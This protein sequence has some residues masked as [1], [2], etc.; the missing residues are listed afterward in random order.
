[1]PTTTRGKKIQNE[2]D[3]NVRQGNKWNK[4]NNELSWDELEFFFCYF[5]SLW[6]QSYNVCLWHQPAFPFFF[7]SL[8]EIWIIKFSQKE[9]ISSSS[10][11][12]VYIVLLFSYYLLLYITHTHTHTHTFVSDGCLIVSLFP[13]LIHWW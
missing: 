1:M 9:L 6:K 3:S 12:F 2:K 11:F 8:P 13:F 5:D 4:N 7:I 10:F